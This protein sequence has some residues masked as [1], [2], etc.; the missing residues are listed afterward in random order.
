MG[1]TNVR[2]WLDDLLP[3]ALAPEDPLELADLVTDTP[4]L[5]AAPEIYER[6][7]DRAGGIVKP[8][9]VP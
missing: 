1:H 7:R 5:E 8:V 2:R 4:S 3:L 9:F 6:F